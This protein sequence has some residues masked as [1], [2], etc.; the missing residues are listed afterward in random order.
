MLSRC[1]SLL[2]AGAA[3]AA[4]VAF[5]GEGR[6][7]LVCEEPVYDYG[8]VDNT[9]PVE[10]AFVLRNEGT[11]P[12][13]ITQ[14]KTG[15]GCTS[16]SAGTNSIPAG[17]QTTVS[18]RL[19]LH[20]RVGLREVS[21][22]VSTD[23]P[24]QPHCQLRFTGTA[25][26]S[27]EIVPSS[28]MLSLS[29]E[30]PVATQDVRVVSRSDEPMNVTGIRQSPEALDVRIVTNRP[31]HEFTVSVAARAPQEQG[32][33]R[34]G[35]L[36]LLTDHPRHPVV[37]I[38]F[39]IVRYADLAVAPRELLFAPAESGAQTRFLV[40]RSARQRTFSI[41]SMTCALPDVPLEVLRSG[42][43][44]HHVRVGPVTPSAAFDGA[45]L[46]IETDLPGAE[47]LEVPLRI[48]RPSPDGAAP[49]SGGRP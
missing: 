3:V 19:S 18:A 48:V 23:D 26:A 21:I 8:S 4:G 12:L 22:Y 15:C 42:G 34:G 45:V 28:I 2:A 29:K 49:A 10:H 14:I 37:A 13:A 31:G 33:L 41:R 16:A 40:V 43:F 11:A 39:G 6:P 30:D 9:V 27:F 1:L 44:W 35:S 32:D 25:L 36:E 24:D 47:P 38:P 46:R 7:K 20:G 5:A 17:G